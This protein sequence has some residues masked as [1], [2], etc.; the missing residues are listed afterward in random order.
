MG[1]VSKITSKQFR[2]GKNIFNFDENFIKNC[3]KNSSIG[4]TFEVDVEY[5]KHL[6]DSYNDF[7]FIQFFSTKKNDD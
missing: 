3:N 4:Y 7:H 6:H 1:N 2:M 5:P